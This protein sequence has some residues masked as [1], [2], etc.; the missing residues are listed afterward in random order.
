[1]LIVVVSTCFIL[2]LVDLTVRVILGH[3]QQDLASNY[4]VHASLSQYPMF[5]RSLSA[6]YTCH[7]VKYVVD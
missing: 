1:M 3:G 5:T 7:R 6:E 2:L 4:A